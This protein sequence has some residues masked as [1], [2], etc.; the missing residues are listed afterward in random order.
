MV[1]TNGDI[2][3][4]KHGQNAQILF[5]GL[6]NFDGCSL[7][8]TGDYYIMSLNDTNYFTADGKIFNIGVYVNDFDFNHTFK[9]EYRT[10]TNA[11]IDDFYKLD[12]ETG[13]YTYSY[14]DE[15]AKFANEIYNKEGKVVAFG[16]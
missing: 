4:L 15:R 16:V 3:Y 10:Q 12:T 9:F 11:N 7:D 13:V 5:N 8:P 6:E 1:Y 2:V 14:W